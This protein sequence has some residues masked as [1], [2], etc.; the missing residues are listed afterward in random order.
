[1]AV[2]AQHE[3]VAALET[4]DFARILGTAETDELEFKQQPYRITERLQKWELAKDV[5][6]LA[7]QRG[8]V[9]VIGYRT[10][11]RPNELVDT[12]LEHREV[13]KDL[14]DW[15]AYRHTLQ[16]WVHPPLAGIAGQWYPRDPA[17]ARGVFVLI[18]PAQPEESKYFVVHEM[19]RADEAFPGAVGI[20]VRHDDHVLWLQ[21][22]AVHALLREAFWWRRHGPAVAAVAGPDAGQRDAAQRIR[23]RCEAIEERAG[24]QEI[25]FIALHAMPEALLPREDDFYAENGLKGH[26][27]NPPA[28]YRHG[29]NL[30]TGA[31][32]E[33]QRDGSIVSGTNRRLLWL[34]PDGFLSAAGRGDEDFFGWFFNQPGRRAHRFELEGGYRVL[35][36]VLSVRESVPQAAVAYGLG[37]VALARR[38][39]QARRCCAS[40]GLGDGRES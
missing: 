32:A 10:E 6:A 18:V 39:R 20:P 2:A 27:A 11:K 33:V 26:I 4:G 25:P 28:L 13:P 1:M 22:Q 23:T 17:I 31:P 14:V 7:N 38:F 37:A 19:A 5:A 16:T 8:G 24:W 30:L 9:I 35:P 34:S 3:L 29:F 15:R 36:G 12:V 40:P 21:P